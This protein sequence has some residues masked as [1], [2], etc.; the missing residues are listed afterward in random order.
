VNKT[1]RPTLSNLLRPLAI[2]ALALA[3]APAL[4]FAAVVRAFVPDPAMRPSTLSRHA[5]A[6]LNAIGLIA[7]AHAVVAWFKW[8]SSR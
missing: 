6:T 1:V 7:A 3:L 4:A 8:R 5:C 2:A